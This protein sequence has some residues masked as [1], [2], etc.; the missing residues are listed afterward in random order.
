MKKKSKDTL[1]ESDYLLIPATM[2]K[3]LGMKAMDLATCIFGVIHGFTKD[4]E[5][6]YKAHIETFQQW[7]NASPR[8]IKYAVEDLLANGYIGRRPCVY[9]G[10]KSFEYWSNLDEMIARARAG[11]DVRFVRQAKGAKSAP[12]TKVQKVHDEGAKSALLQAQKVHDEGA[13]SALSPLYQMN[14]S[15][16]FQY[17]NNIFF[18]Q[19]GAVPAP[20]SEQEKEEF[21]AIFFMKNAADPAAEATR[22][23]EH[24]AARGWTAGSAKFDTPIKRRHLAENWTDFKTGDERLTVGNGP[25][26]DKKRQAAVNRAFL[27][28]LGDLYAYAMEHPE[29]GF[30]PRALLNTESRVRIQ[31][32]DGGPAYDIVWVNAYD[33]VQDWLTRHIKE[34]AP[35]IRNR[36]NRFEG[37]YFERAAA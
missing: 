8:A 36:F 27:D 25:D 7:T 2:L 33:D 16:S 28:M 21:F 11:E 3:Y 14:I 37:V 18:Q 4:G 13:K 35:I 10:K 20:V 5:Q 32:R 29:E 17:F 24:N 9:D 12:E 26:A 6:T 31:Y 23:I 19:L 34:L 15:I 22:F 1:R 30:K